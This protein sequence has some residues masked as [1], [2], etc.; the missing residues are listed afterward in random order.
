MKQMNLCGMTHLHWLHVDV[1]VPGNMS[2]VGRIQLVDSDEFLSAKFVLKLKTC[3]CVNYS[4]FA[5]L[6]NHPFSDDQLLHLAYFLCLLV[7][8]GHAS[9][10]LS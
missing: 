6:L 1:E 9:V 10:N 8:Q 7:V 3:L 4:R 5:E 2:P